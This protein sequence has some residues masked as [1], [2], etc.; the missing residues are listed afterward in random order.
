MGTDN[1]NIWFWVLGIIA[2]GIIAWAIYGSANPTTTNSD[3]YGTPATQ[4]D[5]P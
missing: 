5:P 2:V 3:G 1:N 4:G